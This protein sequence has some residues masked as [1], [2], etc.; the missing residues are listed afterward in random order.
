MKTTLRA[1]ESVVSDL[2]LLYVTTEKADGTKTSTWMANPSEGSGYILNSTP[3]TKYFRYYTK[4]QATEIKKSLDKLEKLSPF[5]GD[6][7]KTTYKVMSLKAAVNQT[8]KRMKEQMITRMF[9]NEMAVSQTKSRIDK[10]IRNA[11]SKVIKEI[12][13]YI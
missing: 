1:T 3:S 12:S 6:N 4:K 7:T 2:Y 10:D 11:E 9:A 8:I 5:G 13:L